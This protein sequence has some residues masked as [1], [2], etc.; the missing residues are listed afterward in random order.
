M[1]VTAL[2]GRHIVWMAAHGS[3]CTWRS[4][5]AVSVR[6]VSENRA[7][8]TRPPVWPFFLRPHCALDHTAAR[9]PVASRCRS[10]LNRPAV[11]TKCK[12]AAKRPR[13]FSTEL[14]WIYNVEHNDP[15]TSAWPCCSFSELPKASLAHRSPP[16]ARR[17]CQGVSAPILAPWQTDPELSPRSVMQ[18]R[19]VLTRPNPYRGSTCMNEASSWTLCFARRLLKRMTGFGV[20]GDFQKPRY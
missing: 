8:L 15:L 16:L 5:L 10:F 1:L 11:A 2:H 9:N 18:A 19:P 3:V 4:L 13:T 20:A 6:A 7:G 14:C 12:E 17:P